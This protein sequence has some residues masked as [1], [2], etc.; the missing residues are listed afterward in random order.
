MNEFS[1]R[2]MNQVLKTQTDKRISDDAADLL[3][4]EMTETGIKISEKAIEIAEENGRITV[5][6]SDIR[7]AIR[8]FK[9]IH[10]TTEV[11]L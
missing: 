9:E 2:S 10:A 11:D 6:A 3:G 5:R 4:D 7:E 1:T 8:S